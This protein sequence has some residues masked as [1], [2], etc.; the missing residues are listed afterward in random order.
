MSWDLLLL[1]LPADVG[2]V[3]ELPDDHR[4]EPLGR[5]AE[6]LSALRSRIP[7]VDLTDPTWGQIAGEF[8]SI[9][10]NIGRADPVESI[11]LH[12]RGAGDEALPEIFRIAA[13][14]NCRIVD[15]SGGDLLTPDDTAN[16]HAFQQYRDHAADAAYSPGDANR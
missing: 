7:A 3:S 14:V 16:W 2:S 15:C 1:Q 9:E 11:M 8:W 4:P 12:V 13:A 10:L 6:V 5:Q